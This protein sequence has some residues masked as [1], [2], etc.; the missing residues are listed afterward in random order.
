MQSN[1]ATEI[2][3]LKKFIL[4]TS[5]FFALLVLIRLLIGELI[6]Y[7]TGGGLISANIQYIKQKKLPVDILFMGTSRMKNS[8]IP[9]YFDSLT[10]DNR[11]PGH[12]SFNL[13]MYS[14]RIGENLYLLKHY[15]RSETGKPLKVV[16]IE[17]ANT[18]IPHRDNRQTDRARYWMD[19]PTCRDY[20]LNVMESDGFEKALK[21]GQLTYIISAFLHRSLSLAHLGQEWLKPPIPENK[22]DE[23]R[24]FEKLYGHAAQIPQNTPFDLRISYF[25]SNWIRKQEAHS[26]KLR[27]LPDI[28]AMDH[29]VKLWN[30][31]LVKMKGQGIRVV[32]IV[33]PGLTTERQMALARKLPSENLIDLSDPDRYPDLYDPAVYYDRMHLND[34]G[35]RLMTRHLAEAWNQKCP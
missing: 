25:D 24:G 14:S 18:Y 30:T 20:I 26:K 6:P 16:F 22:L 32:L 2:K 11:E 35:A 10:N 13:S 34:S 29:D 7:H 9:T 15:S 19:A 21:S 28:Q 4:R 8:I 27:L 23:T 12:I 31:W 17:W 5:Y 1:A 3:S 33:V